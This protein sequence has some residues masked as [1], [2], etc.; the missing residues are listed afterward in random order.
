MLDLSDA[1]EQIGSGT[2]VVDLEV[3]TRQGEEGWREEVEYQ[4]GSRFKLFGDDERFAR[5]WIDA[6]AHCK[7]QGGQFASVLSEK[8]KNEFESL[9]IKSKY[10][11]GGGY[12]ERST[13][14][15]TG[16][17]QE[18]RNGDW[19]WTNGAKL[20]EDW[21]Y[22]VALPWDKPPFCMMVSTSMSWY[23]KVCNAAKQ[24]PFVCKFPPQV[25]S[26][27]KKLQLTYRHEEP[28]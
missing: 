14:A 4:E 15:W 3:D 8:E 9:E 10:F 19:L 5:S 16:A 22:E 2:L 20:S 21:K 17:R 12:Q 1:I 7:T 23:Q 11:D 24:Y 27:Q 26:G 18:E 28:T 25:V 6:D 13:L